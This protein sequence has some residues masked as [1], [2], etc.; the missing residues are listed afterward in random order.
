MYAFANNWRLDSGRFFPLGATSIGIPEKYNFE[1]VCQLLST[2]RPRNNKSMFTWNAI[3]G[4]TSLTKFYY[5]F[6]C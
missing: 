2:T 6:R 5:F 1:G 3:V 4:D